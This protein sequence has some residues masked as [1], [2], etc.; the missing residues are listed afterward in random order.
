MKAVDIMTPDVIT[1]APETSVYDAAR[2]LLGR[3]I[4]ALPVLNE[5][6]GLVGLISESDLMRRGE[7]RTD[8]RRSWWHGLITSDLRQASEFLRGQGRRVS[9]V[10]TRNVVC[11]EAGAPLREVAELM[12][13]HVIRRVPVLD[14]P[15]LV[16][17]VSRSDLMRALLVLAP[18]DEA[19]PEV[20]DRVIRQHLLDQLKAH[21]WAGSIVS[22]AIVERGVVHLWGEA[23]T[24]REIDACRALVET[25]AGVRKVSSH[26]VVVKMVI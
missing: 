17:I 4:G 13:N 22:N 18:A 1:V 3:R 23:S 8:K 6:G 10:M 14:G 15:R 12:E 2:L 21:H 20:D 5:V 11:V 19:P 25:V 9:D 24:Q 16:G 26:M 7:T